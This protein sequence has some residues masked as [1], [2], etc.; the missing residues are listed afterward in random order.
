MHKL[1]QQQH[2]SG[3]L[4]AAFDY[5]CVCVCVCVCVRACVP[6]RQSGLRG[7]RA[8]S[9]VLPGTS[10]HKDAA[11]GSSQRPPCS[12]SARPSTCLG[13]ACC[14]KTF[15]NTTVMYVH[16]LCLYFNSISLLFY[17]IA[18]LYLC[19]DIF[20]SLYFYSLFC[21]IC[22]ITFPSWAEQLWRRWTIIWIWSHWRGAARPGGVVVAALTL[23]VEVGGVLL[24][25]ADH[26]DDL[27][28]ELQQLRLEALPLVYRRACWG[29]LTVHPGP[30]GQRD[31]AHRPSCGSFTQEFNVEHLFAFCSGRIIL[32]VFR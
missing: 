12:P 25:A 4:W 22:V 1:A 9:P 11:P 27:H 31:G 8:G 19:L 6:P 23:W 13:E 32:K 24:L 28:E 30:L 17:F 21:I 2:I 10:P 15:I 29:E 5:V 7:S 26:V 3:K 20:D 16:F 18:K 14:M